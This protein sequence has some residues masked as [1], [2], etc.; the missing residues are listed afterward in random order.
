[1]TIV[2]VNKDW[3]IEIDPANFT[4]LHRSVVQDEESK[5]FG[6]EQWIRKGYF[7]TPGGAFLHIV[8]TE[9]VKPGTVI[10]MTEMIEVYRNLGVQFGQS[11]L[12]EMCDRALV[13]IKATVSRGSAAAAVNVDDEPEPAPPKVP[14][15]SKE[16]VPAPVKAP[17]PRKPPEAPT[18]KIRKPSRG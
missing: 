11:S 5:N 14:S 3:R 12:K 8:R 18:K 4:L 9:A 15:K 2:K 1:V 7:S 16:K 6:Q 10:A 17:E 13:E